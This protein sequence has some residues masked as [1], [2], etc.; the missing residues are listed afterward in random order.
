[1]NWVGFIMALGAACSACSMES[2][3]PDDI[4]GTLGDYIAGPNDF[5]GGG[6]DNVRL[7]RS[8][9][10]G[11]LG[12]TVLLDQPLTQLPNP[13]LGHEV[14]YDFGSA[15]IGDTAGYLFL[16]ERVL[17]GFCDDTFDESN[18]PDV[19]ASW[20]LTSG[21]GTFTIVS[22]DEERPEIEPRIDFVLED[23]QFSPTE[24]DGV[25]VSMGTLRWGNIAVGWLPG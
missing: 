2:E 6:C 1:M 12:L 8:S 7:A 23:A 10:D 4:A 25:P 13:A 9:A 14:I 11:T 17:A 18:Q 20:F 24:G 5:G 15:N 21:I 3:L 16:G 19:H 22:A